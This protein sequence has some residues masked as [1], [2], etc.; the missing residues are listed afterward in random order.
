MKRK[1]SFFFTVLLLSMASVL[2]QEHETCN[3]V[4]VSNPPELLGIGGGSFPC[5]TNITISCIPS[6]INGW[7]FVS[8]TEDSIIVSTE[9]CLTFT[10][11]QSCT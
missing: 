5:G 1:I 3:I 7:K 9:L 2:A 6:P 11:T 4:F 10:V 8:W